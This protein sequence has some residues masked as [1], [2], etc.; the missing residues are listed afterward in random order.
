ME[1]SNYV[2]YELCDPMS[3][4]HLVTDSREEAFIY[5][6]KKW[7]VYEHHVTLGRPSLFT[8]AK[9]ILTTTWN[10]NPDFEEN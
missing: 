9:L 4:R 1:T 7:L 5:Y 2:E 6:E 8:Q 3:D 10:N